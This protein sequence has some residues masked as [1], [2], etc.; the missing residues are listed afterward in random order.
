MDVGCREH[1]G[2]AVPGLEIDE[3]HVRQAAGG[4]LETRPGRAAAVD[5]EH[6]LGIVCE[7]SGGGEHQLER[8]RHADVARVHHDGLAVRPSSRR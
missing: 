5:H 2:Q 7:R 3:V 1:L 8:L 6:D 4:D